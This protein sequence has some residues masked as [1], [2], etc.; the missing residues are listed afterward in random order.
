MAFDDH[1]PVGDGDELEPAA[2]PAEQRV[3]DPSALV[4]RLSHPPPGHVP[5]HV[6]LPSVSSPAASGLKPHAGPGIVGP[7]RVVAGLDADAGSLGPIAQTIYDALELGRRR[8][9]VLALREALVTGDREESLLPLWNALAE[10][11]IPQS[12]TVG[13]LLEALRGL[14]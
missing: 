4:V 10:Q 12:L 9:A 13:D 3:A 2:S 7:A 8:A 5:S 1:A 14:E 6:P 11:G